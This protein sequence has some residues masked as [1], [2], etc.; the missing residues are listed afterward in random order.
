KRIPSPQEP[1][2][3][4][5]AEPQPNQLPV[6]VVVQPK[7]AP[8]PAPSVTPP[9]PAPVKAPPLPQAQPQV[10]L[11]PAQPQP[12]AGTPATPP[13]QDATNATPA[14]VQPAP[15]QAPSQT[16]EEILASP[17]F[18]KCTDWLSDFKNIE[19]QK[20]IHK[21]AD[22]GRFVKT[23][24]KYAIIPGA[25]TAAKWMNKHSSEKLAKDLHESAD[26]Y[27]R[28]LPAMVSLFDSSNDKT[29][30]EHAIGIMMPNIQHAT[31]KLALLKATYQ[32]DLL[33]PPAV[34]K[35]TRILTENSQAMFQAM[36][37][38]AMPFTPFDTPSY[39]RSDG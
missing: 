13:S 30:I 36:S 31:N 25:Q 35:L 34:D 10:A 7:V 27:E 5:Q 8:A 6:P 2:K 33:V 39:A 32:G 37:R 16:L 12:P 11:P 24:N 19:A 14:P 17:D 22:K 28:I 29:N 9:Q 20:W 15:Q 1:V 4:V 23:A 21:S 26:I 3:P 18:I 38:I